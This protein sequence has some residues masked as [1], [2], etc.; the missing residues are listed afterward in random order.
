MIL[1]VHDD[2]IETIGWWIS[3]RYRFS[4]DGWD[5]DWF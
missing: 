5:F 4:I 3:Y 1:D 2:Y